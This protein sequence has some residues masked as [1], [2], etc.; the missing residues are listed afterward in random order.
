MTPCAMAMA[1]SAAEMGLARKWQEERR[2]TPEQP[3]DDGEA[4]ADG[5]TESG[6]T[7]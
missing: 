3:D 4:T 5:R 7:R 6:G 2:D 1:F